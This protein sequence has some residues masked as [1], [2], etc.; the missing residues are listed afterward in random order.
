MKTTTEFDSRLSSLNRKITANKSKHLLVKNELNKL[1]T[2]D[3]NYFISKSHFEDGAQ[4][5]L[6]FQPI[7]I[8]FKFV[9][10]NNEWYITSWKSKGISEESI[11][12]LVTSDNSLNPLINYYY[13]NNKIRAKFTGSCLKQYH[14]HYKHK[15]IVNIYIVY[16]LGA[17]T[18]DDIDST[19]K[20]CLFGAI[21][22]TKNTDIDKYGYSSY[23]IGFD[24]RSSLSF[25]DGGFGQNVLCF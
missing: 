24:R 21:T 17:S 13:Y 19:L 9:V 10:I 25:P 14:L 15:N 1:K 22:L 12:P 23:G 4:N 3:S 6:V 7:H 11:K 18:S 2:F 16:K 8:Y 5:Y 20:Y